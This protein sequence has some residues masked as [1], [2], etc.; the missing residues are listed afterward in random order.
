MSKVLFL[1]IIHVYIIIF[2]NNFKKT[3]KN[4]KKQLKNVI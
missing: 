1:I 2:Q 4:N 3:N